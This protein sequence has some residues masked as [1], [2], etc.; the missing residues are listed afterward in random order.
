[1]KN[2]VVRASDSKKCSTDTQTTLHL[3]LEITVGSLFNECKLQ[4]FVKSAVILCRTYYM[5]SS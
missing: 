4:Y 5:D 1:M 3:E 2:P